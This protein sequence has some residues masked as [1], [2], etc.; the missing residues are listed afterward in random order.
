[1]KELYEI[2]HKE[3]QRRGISLRELETLSGVRFKAIHYAEQGKRNLSIEQAD[4]VL[5]ALGKT[6]I[7]GETDAPK[8]PRQPDFTR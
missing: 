3:R 2:I 6:I 8:A 4:K 1:M 5:K 7:L